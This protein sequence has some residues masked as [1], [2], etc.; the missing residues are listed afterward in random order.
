M[1]LPP[2]IGI[3]HHFGGGVYAKET[4][5]PPGMLLTQHRH[6][7][8]HLSILAKGTA[9]VRVEGVERLIHGPSAVLIEAGKVHSVEALTD[10]VWYCIHSTK[11]T[12]AESIDESLIA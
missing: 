12:D 10:V 1:S 2:N 3:T 11:E 9:V 4:A 7:H 6:K 5:I 8:D